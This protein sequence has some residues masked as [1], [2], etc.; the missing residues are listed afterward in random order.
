MVLFDD[1]RRG[2]HDRL[3]RTAV[4]GR[5]GHRDARQ[6]QARKAPSFSEGSASSP[7]NLIG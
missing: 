6:P 5:T 4:L 2:L 7:F 3:A 1:R